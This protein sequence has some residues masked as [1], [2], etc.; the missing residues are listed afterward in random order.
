MP[1]GIKPLVVD[2]SA[3]FEPK[4]G[5]HITPAVEAKFDRVQRRYRTFILLGSHFGGK[6]KLFT[7]PRGMSA[8]ACVEVGRRMWRR[9]RLEAV[10][11]G[12]F[13]FFR[14]LH[15]SGA[16]S[17]PLDQLVLTF[18]PKPEDPGPLLAMIRR[19]FIAVFHESFGDDCV[20]RISGSTYEIGKARVYEPL[21][22]YV[23]GT[24]PY[25][26]AA[27]R[28]GED[29]AELIQKEKGTF[30][31]VRI[32]VSVA[33]ED[34]PDGERVP[35]V[36]YSSRHPRADVERLVKENWHRPLSRLTDEEVEQRS[37]SMVELDDYL[38]ATRARGTVWT[39]RGKV[40]R[41]VSRDYLPV[42]EVMLPESSR[43]DAG[44]Q[45]WLSWDELA[46]RVKQSPRVSKSHASSPSFLE[47]ALYD[48]ETAELIR[49]QR[50]EYCLT[51]DFY[52]LQHVRYYTLGRWKE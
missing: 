19:A 10:L 15:E 5:Y 42:L 6:P 43:L 11:R 32:W 9:S 21:V 37:E 36:Y 41:G 45:P 17:G 35:P 48:L 51:S 14:E 16:S 29:L 31:D 18:A 47:R 23:R 40:V 30:E 2:I 49:T 34:R 44:P 33:K 12:L 50:D 28:A 38:N 26:V 8:S 3:T 39:M 7:Q 24:G 4:S 1:F 13:P 46:E 22:D 27:R 20:F 25:N 52:S